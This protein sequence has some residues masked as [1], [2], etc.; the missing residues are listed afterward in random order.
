MSELE[1]GAKA[2]AWCLLMHADQLPLSRSIQSL[3]LKYDKLLSNFAFDL[4]NLR[5]YTLDFVTAVLDAHYATDADVVVG[6]CRLTL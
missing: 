3:R 6:R 4:F 5:S 1:T 2:E